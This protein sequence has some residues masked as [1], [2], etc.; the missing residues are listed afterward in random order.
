M[1]G[2]YGGHGG[3]AKEVSECGST[4]ALG[5]IDPIVWLCNSIGGLAGC[6]CGAGEPVAEG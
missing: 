5:G 3:E 4:S 6:E 2:L 1:F